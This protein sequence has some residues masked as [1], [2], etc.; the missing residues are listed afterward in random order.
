[1][2]KAQ[3][4]VKISNILGVGTCLKFSKY[5]CK[6]AILHITI[7]P[8]QPLASKADYTLLL[9]RILSAKLKGPILTN[10]TLT[11][12]EKLNDKENEATVNE[13]VKKKVKIPGDLHGNLN[14]LANIKQL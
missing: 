3:L 5:D 10:I 4:L 2:T 12:L 11:Q 13:K 9:H 1:M 8:G 14:K 7:K 6:V